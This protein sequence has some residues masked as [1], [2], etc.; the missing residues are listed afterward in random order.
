MYEQMAVLPI[1]MPA[2]TVRYSV[3]IPARRRPKWQGI[4]VLTQSERNLAHHPMVLFVNADAPENESDSSEYGC[5]VREPEAHFGF[6]HA[7]VALD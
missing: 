6:F 7:S 4:N 5:R 1:W 3:S 2:P